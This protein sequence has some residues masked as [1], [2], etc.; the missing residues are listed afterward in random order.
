MLAY[1][2]PPMKTVSMRN[3]YFYC[4]Y[5][6]WFDKVVVLS[7]SNQIL[8]RQEP[9]PL[10]L[11]DLQLCSTF[12][13]RTLLNRQN[14]KH[15]NQPENEKGKATRF[16]IKLFDSFP[17][18]CIFGEG[19]LIY[20]IHGYFLGKKLIKKE[21]I[22]HLHSSFRPYSDHVI[23]WMLKWHFPKLTWTAD[24]RDLHV[25]PSV[26]NVVF[27]RFQH[28][29]NRQILSRADFVL[30]VSQGLANHLKRYTANNI[31]VLLYGVGQMPA[32]PPCPRR[33]EK[34]T[35]VYTGSLFMDKRDPGPMLVALQELMA[36]NTL[37]SSNFQL[38]YAGKDGASW[39]AYLEKYQL[40]NLYQDLGMLPLNK[41]RQLQSDAHI[42]LLLTYSTNSLTGNLSSK[43]F[44]YLA[45][46]KPLL[47]LLNGPADEELQGILE[48]T[49]AGV[50]ASHSPQ[51]ITRIKSFLL[52][53]FNEWQVNGKVLPS[54]PE[55]SLEEFRWENIVQ[56]YFEEAG[57]LNT[58]R[59]LSK[60]QME[61]EA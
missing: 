50:V 51:D 37:R 55:E 1:Q 59:R 26:G 13:Y 7:T 22:T 57:I 35:V 31:K 60:V 8:M 32:P 28:W 11:E 47:V 9:V 34:F 52:E 46:R 53:K 14:R 21:N 39:K 27:P 6:K 12:D 44:E 30:T 16:L 33:F 25:D 61:H 43:L 5:K 38:V 20:I 58:D 54:V 49:Q 2:F 10:D 29:C 3:Y 24:M 18:N 40:D 42:N 41:A 56:N 23:A 15:I 48:R 36:E 17:L 19:G 45:A 4:E